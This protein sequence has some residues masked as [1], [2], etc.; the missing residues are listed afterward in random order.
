MPDGKTLLF[1]SDRG[2]GFGLWLAA[3]KDGALTLIR[4]DMGDIESVRVSKSG[5][6][7]YTRNVIR[8]AES[9]F[10]VQQIGGSP[11]GSGSFDGELPRWSTDG[12][13]FAFLASERDQLKRAF[14]V[15]LHVYSDKTNEERRYVPSGTVKVAWNAPQWFHDGAG[16]VLWVEESEGAKSPY[17]VD[18]ETG[19]FTRI[20]ENLIDDPEPVAIS[21]DDRT[22]YTVVF[23]AV[24]EGRCSADTK[25]VAVDVRSGATRD[26]VNRAPNTGIV[27]SADD[28]TLYMRT[29]GAGTGGRIA[30]VDVATGKQRDIYVVKSG[31]SLRQSGL[32]VSPNNRTLA[33]ITSESPATSGIELASLPTQRLVRIEV[34]GTGYK[35]LLKNTIPAVDVGNVSWS[36]DGTEIFLQLRLINER[37]LLRIPSDGGAPRVLARANVVS[38]SLSPDASR[39]MVVKGLRTEQQLWVLDNVPSLLKAKR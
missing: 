6:F 30:A 9:A 14:S 12:R 31:E 7:F 11:I 28:K 19:R 18:L 23:K 17:R 24:E 15:T 10:A 36:R 37:I 21:S 38:E 25:I 20:S 39:F 8:N 3:I 27:L 22:V 5:S 4:A 26:I 29:C 1:V 35:E 34:D 32:A 33:I 16:V 2:G 13:S